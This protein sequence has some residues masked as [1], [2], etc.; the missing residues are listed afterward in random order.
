MLRT[1]NGCRVAVLVA[2]CV[3][4]VVMVVLTLPFVLVAFGLH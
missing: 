1:L 3:V 4:V 2:L